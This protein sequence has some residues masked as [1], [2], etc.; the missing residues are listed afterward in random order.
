[1]RRMHLPGYPFARES[2]WLEWTPPASAPTPEP[3]HP[4]LHR[5][6]STMNEQRFESTFTGRE[7]FL[8]D[9]VIRGVKVLLLTW[10]SW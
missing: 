6:D 1:M 3:P 8:A 4:L 9:H 2:Y 7:F 10:A 5:N